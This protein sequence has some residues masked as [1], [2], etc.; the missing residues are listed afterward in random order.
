MFGFLHR[1][2]IRESWSLA[3]GLS[4]IADSLS[5]IKHAEVTPRRDDRTG[6]TVGFDV[7]GAFP[8]GTLSG[9]L[10]TYTLDTSA[11]TIIYSRN[12]GLKM[13]L[14]TW[15]PRA[16]PASP[17]FSVYG[18]DDDR[19]DQLAVRG[20]AGVVCRHTNGWLAVSATNTSEWVYFCLLTGTVTSLSLCVC[21]CV[22]VT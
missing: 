3:G 9:G 22:C 2:W 20:A 13:C 5:A 15:R 8:V 14:M 4:V 12:E 19:V 7:A 11:C 18:C 6:L 10:Y 17:Y 21:V 16:H 1:R